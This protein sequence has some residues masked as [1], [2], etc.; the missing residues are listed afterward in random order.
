VNSQDYRE[1]KFLR[2][3]V[4]GLGVGE[5]HILG[6]QADPRCTVSSICDLNEEKLQEV[7]ARY[8]GTRLTTSPDELLGDTEIDVISIASFDDAHQTQVVSALQQG[9]H[10]FVEKPICLSR[11]GLNDIAKTLRQHPELRLSSNLILRR[12]P[13]FVELRQRIIAGNLGD[14]YYLEGDY[15][16]GRLH[17]LTE[18]WRGEIPGYSVVHGGG[19]HLIDLL[20][21]LTDGKVDEVFAFGN[22][23]SSASS[24]FAGHDTVVAVLKF[25]N[26][27]VAKVSA[28]FASV[29]P[30]HHRVSVYGT[31]G[32]FMQNHLGTAYSSSRD[33]KQSLEWV[34]D[35]YPGAQKGDMLRP[36]VGSILDG[37]PPDVSANEVFRAMDVSLAIVESLASGWP[38]KVGN[39]DWWFA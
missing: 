8:P 16:Y 36:F 7:G 18:G 12:S 24:H 28:N 14:I 30:H 4:I 19:I 23:I 37:S 2:A 15:D 33:T 21:W 32:T 31:H 35:D 26:S 38:V 29:T 20:L 17:K 3:G 22:Q 13:R 9:K 11:S 6:Y 1:T 10:V 27:Q 39:E 5:Q 25:S 34:R